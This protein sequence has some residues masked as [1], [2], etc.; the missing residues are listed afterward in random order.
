MCLYFREDGSLLDP[1]YLKEAFDDITHWSQVYIKFNLEH[2][3]CHTYTQKKQKEH[4]LFRE[5]V[6]V[7]IIRSSSRIEYMNSVG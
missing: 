6:Y 3:Y 4:E 7:S 2:D 5:F 1:S